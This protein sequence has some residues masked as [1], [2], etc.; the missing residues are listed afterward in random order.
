MHPA[1][2]DRLAAI[3]PLERP[4]KPVTPVARVKAPK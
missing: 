1:L 3:E 4:A 2:D